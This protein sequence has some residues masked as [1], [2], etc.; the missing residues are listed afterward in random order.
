MLVV[1]FISGLVPNLLTT[2]LSK[3][4]TPGAMSIATFSQP[5]IAVFIAWLIGL[6][7][8]PHWPVW[9]A[10]ALLLVSQIIIREEV[11]QAAVGTVMMDDRSADSAENKSHLDLQTSVLV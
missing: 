6:Q 3:V 9:L 11:M 2:A 5:P 1:S 10:M 7:Y 8:F 4:F